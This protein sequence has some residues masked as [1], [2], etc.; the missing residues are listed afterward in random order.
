M[1]KFR[2]SKTRYSV[3]TAKKLISRSRL[4]FPFA[5]CS[6][7]FE[8]DL[9]Q[10]GSGKYFLYGKGGIA[11]VFRGTAIDIILPISDREAKEFC[12]EYMAQNAY[13][14]FFPGTGTGTA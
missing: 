4:R 14:D 9:L 8:A 7:F 2:T 12:R 5:D 6:S 1:E 3:K 13:P 10:T 11:S